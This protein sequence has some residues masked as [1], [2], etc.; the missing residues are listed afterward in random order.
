MSLKLYKSSNWWYADLLLNGQRKTVNLNVEV[1]GKRPESLRKRGDIH[2]EDSRREAQRAHDDVKDGMRSER[3]R[4][5]LMEKIR[6][7]GGGKSMMLREV[8]GYAGKELRRG[9]RSEKYV[10]ECISILENFEKALPSGSAVDQVSRAMVGNWFAAL[11]GSARTRNK[12]LKCVQW[13]F[14]QLIADGF[15]EVSPAG[16]L[17]P[18]RGPV[19][20]RAPLSEEEVDRVKAV[21]GDF[22]PVVVCGLST[23]LRLGDCV[24]L[25][26]ESIDF[27]E[28]WISVKTEKTGSRVEIPLAP[29]LRAVLKT[30]RKKGFCFPKYAAMS[31]DAPSA[32]YMKIR[33]RAGVAKDFHCLR[34]TWITN[35]IS[36]GVP[37][38][39][40]RKVTGHQTVDVVLKHYLAPDRAAMRRAFTAAG[41]L[42]ASAA[43]EFAELVRMLERLNPEQLERVRKYAKSFLLDG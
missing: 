14:R 26:Y 15:L 25:R 19:K 18:V 11:E 28:G 38:D 3:E 42:P 39:I 17:R 31:R 2:F 10:L 21:A 5:R 33:K 4:L 37:M 6:F 1:R 35:A 24:R 23:G 22:L 16:G 43:E 29:E 9:E 13:L 30:N 8:A 27:M 40:V 12:K 36:R 20:H 32:I 7:A 41:V 34:V